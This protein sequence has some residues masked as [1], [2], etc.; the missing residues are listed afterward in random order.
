MYY[1]N[2]PIFNDV[3]SGNNLSKLKDGTYVINCDEYESIETHW[4]A[5]HVNKNN[6]F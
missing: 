6:A 5:L 1:Q 4:I 2:E 3:H